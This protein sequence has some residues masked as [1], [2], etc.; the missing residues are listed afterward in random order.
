MVFVNTTWKRGKFSLHEVILHGPLATYHKGPIKICG[1]TIA[2]VIEGITRQ[3]PGFQ[4]H[5]VHGHQRIQI[6]GVNTIEDLYK[7]LEEDTTIH[8]V[9][10]MAGGK[11]GGMTQILIGAALIAAAFVLGPTA[12]LG[13]MLL[14]AGA[15][16]LLGGLS[17][18][19]APTPEDDKDS[20]LKNRYLG[21]PK[22][23]VAVGTRIPILYGRSRVYGHYLAFDVDAVDQSVAPE[24]SGGG[25]K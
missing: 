7:V 13:S 25:G 5:P 12:F 10:Q 17:Q 14:K 1:N 18:M 11:K 23:T 15:L 8:I 4:P 20:D 9:P 24:T 19:L 6:V 21:T 22:N 3:L 16:M 2:E